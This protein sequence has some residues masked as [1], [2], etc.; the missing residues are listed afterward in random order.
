MILTSPA[1]VS[2]EIF[3]LLLRKAPSKLKPKSET[4]LPR[5]ATEVSATAVLH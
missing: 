3:Q 1:S 4:G 5:M 2:N